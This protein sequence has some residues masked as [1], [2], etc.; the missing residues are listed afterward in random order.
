VTAAKQPGHFWMKQSGLPVLVQHLE[1]IGLDP[2]GDRA[3]G[4]ADGVG[5]PTGAVL[6]AWKTVSGRWTRDGSC[7]SCSAPTL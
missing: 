2:A 6:A 5:G 7:W 1:L 4:G 3:G